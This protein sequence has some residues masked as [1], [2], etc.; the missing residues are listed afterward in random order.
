MI[1]EEDK[2][3]LNRIFDDYSYH[4]ILEHVVD[5]LQKERERINNNIKVFGEDKCNEAWLL[6]EMDEE[7]ENSIL[8]SR[9]GNLNK[10]LKLYSQTLPGIFDHNYMQNYISNKLN[11]KIRENGLSNS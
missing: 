11:P 8:L 6:L 4:E 7:H 3:K 9:A 5:Y 2:E 1:N 10:L